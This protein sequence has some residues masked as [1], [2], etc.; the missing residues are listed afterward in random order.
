MTATLASIWRHPIKAVGR[1]A[2]DRAVLRAGETLPGDRVWAIAH[3][4]SKAVDGEWS[5]CAGFLRAA[6][7]PALMAVEARAEGPALHLTH[8]DRPPLR[9]DPDAEPEALIAWLEPLVALG[10]ARPARVVRAPDG[11]GMTDSA[12]PTITL[13]NLTSHRVVE[14]R[15]GRALSIQRWRCNLWI[16][17]LAP[18]EEFDLVGRRLRLGGAVLEGVARIDRCEST[19]ASPE[20]GRRDADLLSVLDGFGHRDFTIGVTVIKGGV[21]APGDILEAA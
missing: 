11:R 17:G 15:L 5:R 20:T 6:S 9:V 13:G 7:S 21:I 2:L 14:G 4:A 12:A 16:D 10:R 1:E 8:P 19:S 3:E 18:W